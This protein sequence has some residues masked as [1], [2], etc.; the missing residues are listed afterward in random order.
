MTSCRINC[1]YSCEQ[2]TSICL[3]GIIKKIFFAFCLCKLLVVCMT[4]CHSMLSVLLLR[5]SY[6]KEQSCS[7]YQMSIKAEDFT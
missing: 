3:L 2:Y 6:R 4:H 1:V 7:S 5:L